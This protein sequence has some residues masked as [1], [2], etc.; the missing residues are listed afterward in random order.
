[1]GRLPMTRL[2]VERPRI[3]AEQSLQFAVVGYQIGIEPVQRAAQSRHACDPAATATPAAAAAAW[4]K[5]GC[6]AHARKHLAGGQSLTAADR[7][8]PADCRGTLQR[9]Q[10]GLRNIV[11]VHRLAQTGPDGS[12]NSRRRIARRAIGVRLLSMPAP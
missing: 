4:R 11:R 6:D 2:G 8:N 9:G 1:M 3:D 5:A 7:Q 12:G 10:H